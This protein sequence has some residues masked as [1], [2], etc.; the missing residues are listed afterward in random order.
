[1]KIRIGIGH[2][3]VTEHDRL[4]DQPGGHPRERAYD[5]AR[6]HLRDHP[7]HL[8][9][10]LARELGEW[11]DELE[12]RRVDSG[13]LSDLA[14]APYTVDPLIGLAY[15]AGRTRRLKLGTGVLILPGRDPVVVAMQL[16]G[17]AALAP[18]R[19]LPAFG[20]RPV[21][22]ADRRAY[23][24][25]PGRRAAV[26]EEA[27][28]VV[29]A[30]LTGPSVTHHGEFFHLDEAAIAPLPAKPLDLWLGGRLPAAMDRVGRLADGWLGSA[31]TPAEAATSL[32]GFLDRF[33]AE[34]G[35]L[36]T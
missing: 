6:D 35:P 21:R 7:H 25:P 31:V 30:L 24:V 26:F 18:G 13:W 32:R 19:V 11:A 23:A 12:A 28:V 3:P 1:M 33:A 10:D 17:L 14:A 16:A 27:L 29:R 4:R 8:P 15:V 9:R 36:Q 2:V 22:P 34:L 5:L 20:V